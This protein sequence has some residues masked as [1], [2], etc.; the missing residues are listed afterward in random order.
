M[1][2][3]WTIGWVT[4]ALGCAA[5]PAHEAPTEP[6]AS[7]PGTSADG[8]PALMLARHPEWV[9]RADVADAS[10]PIG[11][12]TPRRA[13]LRG[14]LSAPSASGAGVEVE[15]A[16]PVRGIDWGFSRSAAPVGVRL[17]DADGRAVPWKTGGRKKRTPP[18]TWDATDTTLRVRLPE[19]VDPDTLLGWTFDVPHLARAE[20]QLHRRSSGLDPVEH[21]L[22]TVLM[23]EGARHGVFLPA[24]SAVAWTL[25]V[26]A[27]R[28]RHLR[29]TVHLLPPFVSSEPG[30]D[31]ATLDVVLALDGTRT[32][33]EQVHLAPGD[34]VGLD[35]DLGEVALPATGSVAVSLE[36]HGGET[37]LLDYVFCEEPTLLVPDA[38][39]TQ[40]LVVVV[41]TLRA[42]RLGAY[43]H[44]RPTSPTIDALAARGV[45]F[46]AAHAPAPW[47]LPSTRSILSGLRPD[48][49]T[50]LGHLGQELAAAGFATALVSGNTFVSRY[51][52]M[53]RGWT[54]HTYSL[55]A[56]ARTQVARARSFIEDHPAQDIA[57][58][59]QLMDPHLPYEEPEG[60]RERFAGPTPDGLVRRFGVTAVK[61][62]TEAGE[63]DDADRAW[64]RARY[65]QNI[66]LADRAIAEVL[67]ALGPDPLVVV[68][69]DHGEEFWDHGGFEHGHT[70]HQELVR[71]PL[72]VS[73]PG[74]PQGVVAEPVSVM[75]VVP[76]L[77]ELLG[78]PAPA[79]HGVD[80]G[81]AMRDAPGAR[82]AL[83]DRPLAFSDLLYDADAF[84]VL[85]DGH[86]K[87]I[88]TRGRESAYD[89]SADPSELDPRAPAAPARFHAALAEALGTP[90]VDGYR[91]A[92]PADLGPES[93]RRTRRG[94]DT[95]VL[96]RPGGFLGAV[97]ARDHAD[98]SG[99]EV[100]IDGDRITLSR[101]P[102]KPWPSEIYVAPAVPLADD[103]APPTLVRH[104]RSSTWPVPGAAAAP[105]PAAPALR[106]V[107]PPDRPV[108]L[109][110]AVFPFAGAGPAALD[111]DPDAEA[112]LEALGYLDD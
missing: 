48:A 85:V 70:L 92:Y 112:A 14:P 2:R 100:V 65:D 22:R 10:R 47:T 1:H 3:V 25:D 61:E 73:G 104:D 28:G 8:P 78:L 82:Q 45:R 93:R 30:S 108:I 102:G 62:W 60:F 71:V 19:S 7:S 4:A 79:S 110:P 6:S 106:A 11:A 32:V 98:K 13:A 63:L 50:P 9:T 41:D 97:G 84:G 74:V 34:A 33:V 16:M 67:E 36:T 15:L 76:T 57:V 56:P 26:D 49:W 81:P 107:G 86:D 77:F 44:H 64:I 109:T 51:V 88:S 42:D 37:D 18:P 55:L 5:G 52:D 31:G 91:L 94:A 23:A 96:E 58:V 59:L 89:L 75:D 87:W 111:L 20:D 53:H 72:V 83:L 103:P 46:D 40:V 24:P 101:A 27:V 43:G 54:R 12:R 90:V 80:L 29:S 66:L 68:V 99:V 17:L 39:P 105:D 69:S 95:L 21:A 38:A 35:V